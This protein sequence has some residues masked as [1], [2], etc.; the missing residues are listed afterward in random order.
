[1]QE[2]LD[3]AR[4]EMAIVAEHGGAVEAVPYM[5]AALV[6][7]HRE[8]IRRIESGEQKVVGQNVYTETE[9]SPLTAD[10]DGGILVVDPDVERHARE[11]LAAW[12]TD[13]DQAAVDAALAELARVAQTDENLME[14]TLAAARAGATTGEWAGT[15]REVFG[16]YRAPTGV[17]EA[18]AIPDHSLDELRDEVERVSE[19]LGRRLKILVGKPGLDGHSNGAEQIAVAARDAGMEVVY[20]GI[21]LTP[22]Q[23]AASALQEGVHVVGLS[24][25]SG[26]HR[27]L[28]PSVIAA[29]R[30]AGVGDVPV[31]VGGIIPPADEAPLRE[32]GVAAVYTPKDFDITR[33][34]RDVVGLVAARNG[35]AAAA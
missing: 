35:I 16:S 15:L 3:G 28:I 12:R 1:V 27:E 34:M 32:A 33:I 2:L 25:L 10:G 30:D 5:K 14:A 20:E 13:R 18:A 9:P 22:Q 23:I 8:R 11:A 6:E 24:I 31:V 4:A 21:R 19:Q 7:S 29:L 17:G 26:S